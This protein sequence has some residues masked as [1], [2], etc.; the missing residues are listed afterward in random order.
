MS[1]A[2][3]SAA[4]CLG[5]VAV[6]LPM[7][8]SNDPGELEFQQLRPAERQYV[9]RYIVLERARAVVMNDPLRGAAILD[10]LAETWG[11][12]AA[13]SAEGWLPADPYRAARLQE[14][15]ARLLAAEFDSLVQ[16]P[17]PRRLTA[18]LPMPAATDSM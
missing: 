9:E 18:P 17:Y 5:L 1:R 12:T 14:L 8:C 13:S 7:G 4:L 3:V 15:L 11:D 2:I 10:S 6:G 16:A